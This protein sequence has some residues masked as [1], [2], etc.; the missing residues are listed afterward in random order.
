MILACQKY[1][2]EA[3]RLATENDSPLKDII[4]AYAADLKQGMSPKDA[5]KR[6]VVDSNVQMPQKWGLGPMCGLAIRAVA[7]L[8]DFARPSGG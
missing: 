7:I 1:L 6:H 5:Y 8:A 4:R 3:A 2:A